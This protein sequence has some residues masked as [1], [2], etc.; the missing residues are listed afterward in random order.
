MCC[1]LCVGVCVCV[2]VCVDVCLVLY[3]YLCVWMCVEHVLYMLVCSVPS[4]YSCSTSHNLSTHPHTHT[5]TPI[6]TSTHTHTLT[7]SVSLSLNHTHTPNNTELIGF[8]IPSVVIAHFMHEYNTFNVFR[9][10][11]TVG[12]RCQDLENPQLRDYYKVS[13]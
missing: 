10:N 6:N 2:D 3:V 13:E 11:G 4:L 9:G 5:H 1:V 7:L 8:I 12:F